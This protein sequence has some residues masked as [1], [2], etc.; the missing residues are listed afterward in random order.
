MIDRMPRR[1]QRLLDNAQP[2]LAAVTDAFAHYRSTGAGSLSSRWST[3]RRPAAFMTSQRSLPL[4]ERP[5]APHI[6]L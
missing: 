3:G 6:E 1:A 2:D 5:A 4:I